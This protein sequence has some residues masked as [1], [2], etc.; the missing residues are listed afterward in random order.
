MTFT[1][2]QIEQYV[3]VAAIPVGTAGAAKTATI[4]LS[5]PTGSA[6]LLRSSGTVILGNG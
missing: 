1:A 6:T 2:G 3:Y 5:S 4:T